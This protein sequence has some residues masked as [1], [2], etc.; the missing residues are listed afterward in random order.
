MSNKKRLNYQKVG[1][2]YGQKNWV[3]YGL[4]QSKNELGWA[5]FRFTNY[6]DIQKWWELV[7]SAYLIVS[8]HSYQLEH[9]LDSVARKQKLGAVNIL[10][11]HPDWDRDIGWKNI[12]NNLRLILAPWLC[13][14][15]IKK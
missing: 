3:E 5:D 11:E 2:L 14:N 13:F 10:S 9:T 4:K 6:A 7:C 1:N 12:L 8:S 15:Q